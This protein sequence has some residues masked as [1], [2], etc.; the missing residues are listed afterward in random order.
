MAAPDRIA[1]SPLGRAAVLYSSVA[2]SAQV[3]T[4][5]PEAPTLRRQMALPWQ[6]DAIAVS[7]RGAVLA[8]AAG[9]LW[10][11]SPGTPPA[12]VQPGDV[13][14][15]AFFADRDDAAFAADGALWLRRGTAITPLGGVSGAVAVQAGTGYVFAA[16]QESIVR[17]ELATRIRTETACEFTVTALDPMSADAVFRLNQAGDAPLYLYDG[18]RPEPRVLFVPDA[19]EGVA[20]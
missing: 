18:S 11:I 16:T 13:E 15:I 8:G 12:I 7:D 19:P 1:V 4:G 9:A 17:I 2:R 6:I 14:A 3:I 10:S 20:R 5:L